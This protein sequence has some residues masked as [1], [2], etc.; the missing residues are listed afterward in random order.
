MTFEHGSSQKDGSG[1][2]VEHLP[3]TVAAWISNQVRAGTLLPGD[4]LPSERQLCERFS[5]SRA[6]VREALSQLRSDGVVATRQGVGAFVTSHQPFRIDDVPLEEKESLAQV[7]ELLFAIEVAA[8]RI[9][10]TRRTAADLKAIRR[11]LI[12]MEFA[13]ADDRP[14]A[15]E[16]YGFHLAIVEATHNRHFMALTANIEPAVHGMVTRARANTAARHPERVVQVQAEHRAIYEA[17]E[18]KDPD[19]AGAAAERHLRNAAMRIGVRVGAG[20][21]VRPRSKARAPGGTAAG[22]KRG[23]R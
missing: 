8:T 10:A 13:I 16:D 6:V 20:A 18:A 2:G 1:Q 7:F 9:A 21:S 12:G 17:I 14:G 22:P 19:A 11:A 3:D 4:R 23:A 5:V 15:D